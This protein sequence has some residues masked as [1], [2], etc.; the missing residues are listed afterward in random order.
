MSSTAFAVGL[1][2]NGTCYPVVHVIECCHQVYDIIEGGRQ[3]VLFTDLKEAELA[4][5][6]ER[7]A[8]GGCSCKRK[9]EQELGRPLP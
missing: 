1:N 3:V 5:T 9:T 2:D 7:I 6:E 8:E 4:A